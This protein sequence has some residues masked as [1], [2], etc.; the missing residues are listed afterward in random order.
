MQGLHYA[1]GVL[2]PVDQ[3]PAA[4][5]DW[6]ASQPP[7]PTTIAILTA[8]DVTS[9]M[10]TQGTVAAA[11]ARGIKVVFMQKYP[12]GT[13]NLYPLVQ[14]AKATNPDIFFDSGHFLEAVAAAKAAKDLMLD[15]K[16][17]SFAVGPQQPEFAQA[18]GQVA[19]YTVT[20][21]PW[22]A[23]ARFKADMGPSSAEYVAA[24]R[25]KYHLQTD[26]G[27]VTADATA[28]GLALE[29]AIEHADS[30]DPT[31]V[32][33]ALATLDANTFY[34]RLKFDAQGQNTFHNVLVVQILGGKVQTVWPTELASAPGT[35][36]APTFESR[37][38][39]AAAPPKAKLPGTG[40]APSR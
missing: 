18:L 3:Y 32:R 12:A 6:E 21:T 28:A 10:A 25:K 13:T 1:F 11:Q 36:P 17:L 30:L 34:G 16:V 14:Q 29:L 2:A 33:D 24:Y 26:P 8:D 23:Q 40:V 7:K 5:I 31:K 38:G 9:L 27:F 37:F 4:A 15:A 22:T 19:D 35:W 20:A 39:I